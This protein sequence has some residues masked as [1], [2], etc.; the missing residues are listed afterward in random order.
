MNLVATQFNVNRDAFTVSLTT[1][2]TRGPQSREA[3]LTDDGDGL[4]R[5]SGN[6]SVDEKVAY[7][8]LVV[9][10]SYRINCT[11]LVQSTGENVPGPQGTP[12]LASLFEFTPEQ[13]SGTLS[14]HVTL[15]CSALAGERIV[16]QLEL[17]DGKGMSITGDDED[18]DGPDARRRTHHHRN[19]LRCV[20]RRCLRHGKR[21]HRGG[22]PGYD[23]LRSNRSYMASPSTTRQPATLRDAQARSSRRT[24]SSFPK[25]PGASN[26]DL[27]VDERRHRPAMTS[28]S[29][30]S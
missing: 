29:S 1:S 23:G 10:K 20:G 25:A 27:G 30:T 12:A 22:A 24:S 11:A 28:S 18:R 5:P 9:G 6:V 16:M 4:V 3:P 13:S 8:N 7:R 15:D 2:L 19:G 17:V 14:L 26:F 21:G